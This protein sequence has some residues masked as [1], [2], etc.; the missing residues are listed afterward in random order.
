MIAR[1]PGLGRCLRAALATL[2]LAGGARAQSKPLAPDAVSVVFPDC[3]VEP[4][5]YDASLASL[6][7]ELALEGVERVERARGDADPEGARIQVFADCGGEASAILVVVV[8]PRTSG[9]SRR[10]DLAGVPA[11]HRPRA[12]ALVAAELARS[13]WTR[14]PSLADPPTTPPPA[15]GRSSEPNPSRPAPADTRSEPT[16]RAAGAEAVGSEGR[17]RPRPRPQPQSRSRARAERG[18]RPWWIAPSLAGRLFVPESTLL[19]GAGLKLG[20]WR[21]RAGVDGL[22]GSRPDDLGSVTFGLVA[23]SVGFDLLTHEGRA[24]R[25][26]AGPRAALGL[27][28]SEAHAPAPAIAGNAREAYYDFALALGAELRLAR[29]LTGQ[30]GLEGGAARGLEIYADERRLAVIGGGFVGA[31]LGIGLAP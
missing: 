16:T 12:L 10:T 27:A 7:V 29:H 24:T 4:F 28:L 20:W 21:L 14:P 22:G 1:G 19:G 18:P 17:S 2:A 6:R 8:D 15:A 25:V 9:A 3:P 23:G 26:R 31:Q 11:A 30:L 5:P 13:V